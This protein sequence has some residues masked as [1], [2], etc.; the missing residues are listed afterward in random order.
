MSIPGPPKAAK[1]VIGLLMNDRQLLNPIAKKLIEKFGGADL[2]GPWMPFDFT[3]YYDSELGS[4]IVRRMFSF[5][6]LVDQSALA[7]IKVFTNEIEQD[8]AENGRRSV[9]IDPGYL[10]A[11]RF[12]LATGKNYTHRIYIGKGIYAD[13]T[14]IYQKGDF[15]TLPWTYP[16]YADSE[17]LTLLNKI[18]NRYLFDLKKTGIQ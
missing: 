2:I 6:R 12:V 4:P 16:D 3:T 11:E 9:N 5:K 10:L 17:M 14:L 8:A 18:R 7:E 13:L 1:L 15:R